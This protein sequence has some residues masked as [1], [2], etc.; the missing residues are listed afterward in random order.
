MEPAPF[1]PPIDEVEDYI[2]EAGG[3]WHAVR[4]LLD[5]VALLTAECEANQRATS[6]GYVRRRPS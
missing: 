2:R 5:E 3:T 4:Q 1:A 6:A